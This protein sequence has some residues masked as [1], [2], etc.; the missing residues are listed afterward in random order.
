MVDMRGGSHDDGRV[1]DPEH[2]PQPRP[3]AGPWWQRP[4]RALPVMVGLNVAV[5]TLWQLGRSSEPLAW[6]M[7]LNFVVSAT[8]LAHGLVWTALT[9]VFSHQELWHLVLNMVVLWS[10][11]SILER[12]WGWKA[13][14]AF[15]LAAGVA[16]SV[17]HAAACVWILH[18]PR[19]SALGASGAVAGVLMA[20]A[21]LF[22]RQKILVMGIVP[23]PAA[24]GVLAFAA[25]D[26]WGLVAQSRGG[27]L[28]I[29]H[30]AHLGGAAAGAILVLVFRRWLGRGGAAMPEGPTRS[31]MK[32][33]ARLRKKLEAGGPESLTA[34]EIRFLAELRRRF[35]GQ[36]GE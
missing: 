14:T 25:L 35:G 20:Y 28:P 8:R 10:F 18:D 32:E 17:A 19:I 13:F 21:M 16:G 36:R 31:E 7:L 3:D 15:Y 27:G 9:S 29:G 12:L 2:T 6:F 11:G 23:V 1:M 5:F 22:P 33:L 30:G 34:E 24:A 4:L 26:V